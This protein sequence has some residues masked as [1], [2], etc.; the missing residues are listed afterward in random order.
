M[1]NYVFL[2]SHHTIIWPCSCSRLPKKRTDIEMTVY[3][4]DL[5][6]GARIA[7]QYTGND[8]DFIISR[9]GTAQMIRDAVDI[10]LLKSKYH[11]LICCAVFRLH[12]MHLS[13][14]H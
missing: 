3:T 14:T 5:E 7:S 6:D 8:Y 11:R 10:P 2:A 1:K 9:G 13:I 4:G 12:K